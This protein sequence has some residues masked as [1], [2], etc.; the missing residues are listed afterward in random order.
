M[1]NQT[2]RINNINALKYNFSINAKVVRLWRQY[3][4]DGDTLAS[5]D[6]IPIDQKTKVKAIQSVFS[7]KYGFSFVPFTEFVEDNVKEEQVVDVIR[8]IAA[9]GDVVHGERKGK[10]NRRILVELTDIEVWVFSL[11][12]LETWGVKFVDQ[13][14]SI[15]ITSPLFASTIV[16]SI[17]YFP[18]FV[19][20]IYFCFFAMA[21]EGPANMIARFVN[22]MRDEAATARECVAQMTALIVEIK[23][24]EDQKEIHDSLLAAKDAK[25]GEEAKLV[26]LNDVI[27]EALDEVDTLEN[28]VEILDG[29]VVESPRL[30]D[31]IK[32]V[33]DQAR[34]EKASFAT[35]MRELCCSLQVSLSKKRRLAAELEG[36]GDQGD[37]VR[38]FEKMKE[39]VSCDLVTLG[40]LK[41]L[42]DCA[43]VRVDLKDGYL[44]DVEGKVLVFVWILN[45]FVV[46]GSLDN[47]L[48]INS[49]IASA[50]SFLGVRIALSFSISSDKA[51]QFVSHSFTGLATS[52][53]N[54]IVL[55]MSRSCGPNAHRLASE[56]AFVYSQ[57]SFKRPYA[58]QTSLNVAYNLWLEKFLRLLDTYGY[59][60]D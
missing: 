16:S 2:F 29:E 30:P 7:P 25:R 35:L 17:A 50:L 45:F 47:C 19:L 27:V 60:F 56:R 34:K 55:N 1:V 38:A 22:R 18:K 52:Q 11:G 23:A 6:M 3:Y 10:K 33:F 9:V 41:Q 58:K 5:M 49:L 20:V 32:V 12:V 31:K 21:G 24:M 40:D 48:N 26:A 59:L 51:C 36:L 28:N 46:T 4:Y 8:L 43:Q 15:V 37:A 57:S 39:I 44:A 13:R 53:N 54:N 14:E 42:L